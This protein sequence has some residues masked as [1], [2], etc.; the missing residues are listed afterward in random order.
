MR[1]YMKICE[2][3]A[4]ISISNSTNFENAYKFNDFDQI[5]SQ[6]VSIAIC[7]KDTN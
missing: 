2:N 1:G 6:I 3:T 7:K 4:D 5:L